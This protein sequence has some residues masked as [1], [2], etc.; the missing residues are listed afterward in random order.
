MDAAIICIG[1]LALLLIGLRMAVSV[2]RGNVN[3]LG[4]L[5]LTV[6]LLFGL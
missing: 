1:L 2:T 3:T 4:G 6:A 5:A